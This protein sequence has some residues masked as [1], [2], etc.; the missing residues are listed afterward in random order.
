MQPV[1]RDKLILLLWPDA[2]QDA[3]RRRLTRLLSALRSE[4]PHPDLLQTTPVTVS[5]NPDLV[6]SD[7]AA[8]A[9]LAGARD[10]TQ[11]ETAVSLVR[12][13][14]LNGFYLANNV[15]FDAWQSRQHHF[16]ERRYLAL[17]ANL[18]TA[19]R[20]RGQL[21][22]AIDYA[23]R[24]LE[25]DDLTEEMHRHLI[26]LYAQAGDRSA[27]LRQF[28][29]C[30][31]VLERELG[32]V[33]LPETRAAYEAAREGLPQVV[34]EAQ[35]VPEWEIL[36]S[37][38]LPLV[39]RE[40]ALAALEKAYW[41]FRHG[42]VILIT[43]T[44]GVGKSR[45]MR[46]FARRS[47]ALVLTGISQPGESSMPYQPLLQALRQALP[48][49][50]RWQKTPT[51]WLAELARL[52]PELRSYFPDVPVATDVEPEQAQARLYEGL[53]QVFTGL[54]ADSSL[55]LCLDDVHWADTAT[56]GWLLYLTHQLAGSGICVAAASRTPE[57]QAVDN[58]QRALRRADLTAEVSLDGLAETAITALLHQLPKSPPQ[59]EQ[60]AARLH[61]ATG[62]NAFFVLETIRELLSVGQLAGDA[63]LPLPPTVRDA[64][65]RRAKRLS[66]LTRQVLEVT[67]VLAPTATLEAITETAGR[68]ELETAVSL[69][70][71][72]DWQMLWSDGERFHFRHALARDA[73]YQEV[74]PWRRRLLHRRAANA[75]NNLR[76]T[77]HELAVIAYHYEEAGDRLQAIDCY[78]RAAVSEAALYAYQAA[79]Q[80]LRR[81]LALAEETPDTAGLLPDLHETLADNLSILGEFAAAE[82]AYRF[83]L[84][85]TSDNDR[86]HMA[87]L[88]RKLAATLPAQH[89]TIEAETI[90]RT[91]L[92]RLDQ[93]SSA[94]AS[95]EWQFARLN[96]LL[97][98]LDALYF[99]F[100][101][102]PMGALQ[103]QT[104]SLLEKIGT[105]EQ[106]SNYYSRLGQ[107][108]FLQDQFRVLDQS[109]P[110][111]RTSLAF[112]EESG[113]GRLIARQ[114]FHLG[115][116]TLWHGRREETEKL[117]HQA[118]EA[119][120]EFGDA[121]LQNQCLVYLTILYRFQGSADQMT[122]Y[123]PQLTAISRQVGQ[124][125]YIGVSQANGAWLHY[126]AREWVQARRQAEMAIATW[127]TYPFQWLAHWILLALAL[128][129]NQLPNAFLAARAMLSTT[130]QRLP[131][132]I[133][134][135]LRT[136]VSAW[137]ADDAPSARRALETAVN[138]AHQHGYL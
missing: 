13:P 57:Q 106:Q 58:W 82:E 43:G 75:L 22:I 137:E 45:L 107:M 74:S 101:P 12:G 105:T 134:R 132:E 7:A 64:V 89:R 73:I 9:A 96:I 31:L 54:A 19:N 129:E 27:A 8:F 84:S 17:L 110:M 80:H 6:W 76:D 11:W 44:A 78:R 46:D 125:N 120:Q 138:L 88:E 50:S 68:E 118:L 136:A 24:Y 49:H 30:V 128:R 113:S 100:Q 10:A 3:A 71:L 131:D 65:L 130:Q 83:A 98:L 60:L 29:Q 16:F 117:F 95:P 47:D 25:T 61:A 70:E 86:L 4:L 55:L 51:I 26:E 41:R 2:S 119:A 63:A 33:P 1:A 94:A 122:S 116:T 108:A 23:Q 114:Q 72:V 127:S 38:D 18:V 52:L 133:D 14:F 93:S 92:A 91:A 102:A 123:L 67:S 66:P 48:L 34:P 121:W 5:L 42:G 97:S 40:E 15:E 103:A 37:L 124:S 115:F 90:Y 32:V 56:Y 62:G 59:T 77:D 109:V 53:W 104:E 81:A 126:R 111:A 20:G 99:Q 21:D 39:G 87:E 112:A 28:E 36:P 85:S 69:E 35:P 135:G 79:A